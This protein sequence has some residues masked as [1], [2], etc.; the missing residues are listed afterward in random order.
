MHE[1]WILSE[2]SVVASA[3]AD[4][5]RICGTTMAR[6]STA[7][8]LCVVGAPLG[9]VLGPGH[10]QRV[11]LCVLDAE[12]VVTQARSLAGRQVA[13]TSGSHTVVVAPAGVFEAHGI[14]P[15]TQLEFREVA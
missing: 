2:G 5:R 7:Q 6:T 11:D 1:G 14:A 3:V 4:H 10:H 13:L 9:V 12:G 15:G 8:G